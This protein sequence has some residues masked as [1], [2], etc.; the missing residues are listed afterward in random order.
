MYYEEIITVVAGKIS[1][2]YVISICVTQAVVIY[3]NP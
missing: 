1:H 2:F 3:L